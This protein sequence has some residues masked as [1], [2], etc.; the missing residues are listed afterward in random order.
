MGFLLFLGILSVYAI[1]DN[2]R[3]L[4]YLGLRLPVE[5]APAVECMVEI[6]RILVENF[7]NP[8]ISKPSWFFFFKSAFQ[9]RVFYNPLEN[10]CHFLFK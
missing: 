10:I 8:F 2:Q 1:V 5:G 6:M 7:L 3:S 9:E 4:F